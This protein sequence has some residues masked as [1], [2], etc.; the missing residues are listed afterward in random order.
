MIQNLHKLNY[1]EKH[2][3]LNNSFWITGTTNITLQEALHGGSYVFEKSFDYI[4]TANKRIKSSTIHFQVDDFLKIKVND[5]PES[6][7][8]D[9]D[10]KLDPFQLDIEI[11]PGHNVFQFNVRNREFTNEELKGIANNNPYDFIYTLVIELEDV[12]NS[13]VENEENRNSLASQFEN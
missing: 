8:F 11:S 13:N 5:K 3:I 6:L 2:A 7:E 9:G 10:I 1:A 12:E 4:P